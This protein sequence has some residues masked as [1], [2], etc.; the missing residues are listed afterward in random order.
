MI[1]SNKSDIA[2]R[3]IVQLYIRDMVASV[4]RPVKELKNFVP[5]DLCANENKIV[6]FEIV[7]E[8]LGF[9]DAEGT[10]KIEEGLFELYIGFDSATENCTRFYYMGKLHER[11]I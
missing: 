6:S 7:S 9:Y 5:L 3:T 8:M 2:A 10:Y 1:I 11:R 4:C